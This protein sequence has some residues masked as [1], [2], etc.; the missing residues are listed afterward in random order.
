MAATASTGF[1]GRL[2]T[3]TIK[4]IRTERRALVTVVMTAEL[5]LV[6]ISRS[7]YP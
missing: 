5:R 6:G 2:Q 3:N 7:G 4:V 1:T